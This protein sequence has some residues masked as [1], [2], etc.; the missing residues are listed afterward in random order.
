MQFTSLDIAM[1]TPSLADLVS[2]ASAGC[3]GDRAT[4]LY[5]DACQ[6]SSH[7]PAWRDRNALTSIRAVDAASA[8]TKASA[9]AESRQPAERV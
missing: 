9:T 4:S 5:G 1:L 2:T 8:A 7:A 3:T 6:F